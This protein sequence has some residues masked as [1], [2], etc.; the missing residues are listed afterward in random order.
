MEALDK[1]VCVVRQDTNL[2]NVE[3]ASTIIE[4]ENTCVTENERIT[5]A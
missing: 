4:P 5:G 3:D 2:V 1:N